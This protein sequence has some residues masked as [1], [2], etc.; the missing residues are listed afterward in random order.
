[1]VASESEAAFTKISNRVRPSLS[2]QLFYNKHHEPE[3]L[4]IHILCWCRM[5]KDI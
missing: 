5:E 1:M 2:V 3:Y 4:Q